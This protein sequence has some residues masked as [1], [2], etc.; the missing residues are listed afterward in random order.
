MA[1]ARGLGRVLDERDTVLVAQ[2]L[3]GDEVGE[4]AVQVDR[5]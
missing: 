4:A 1:S 2:R 3:E 5:R